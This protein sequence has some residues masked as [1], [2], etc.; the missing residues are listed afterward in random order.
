M[1]RR[2]WYCRIL[3]AA[4]IWLGAVPTSVFAQADIKVKV[5]APSADGQEVGRRANIKG[6]AVIPQDNFLW[7]L[8]HRIRGFEDRWWP[9][10]EVTVN[11]KSSTWIKNVR[12]GE[13][14]DIGY[15]FEIAVITVGKTEHELLNRFLFFVKQ[16]GRSDPIMMPS[17]TSPPKYRIVKKVRH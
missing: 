17:T 6:T 15:Q 2:F 12:F 11:A 7:I 1:T 13:K 9:Q 16:T 3:V 4:V 5:I 14:R 8:V 10:G